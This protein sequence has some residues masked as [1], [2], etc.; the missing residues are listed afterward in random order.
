VARRYK[1]P[2]TGKPPKAPK[3]RL[4]P[5]LVNGERLAPEPPRRPPKP[6]PEPLARQAAA[7]LRSEGFHCTTE[8]VLEL[9]VA[10]GKGLGRE[11]ALLQ[12]RVLASVQALR[13][14][15]RAAGEASP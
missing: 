3:R 13:R 8:D 12:R 15:E 14:A 2:T 4:P 1:R 7:A 5:K 9:A 6:V 10:D 11:R